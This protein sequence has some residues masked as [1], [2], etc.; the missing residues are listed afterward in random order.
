M[1]VT[2]TGATGLIGRHLVRRLRERGDE[3]TVLSRDPDRAR[4]SLGVEAVSWDPQAEPAPEAALAGRDA[5]VHLAGE[6]VAQRWSD[7]AKRAIRDSRTIGTRNLVSGL[8]AAEPRP[9]VLA[10]A[11]AVG[12]Y[13]PRGDEPVNESQPPGDDFLAQVCVDWEREADAAAAPGVRVVKLRTGIV[14]DR[15]GGALK[16]MLLPFKAG[17]GG[18]VAGG[19]QYMP[20]IHADD[21]VGMYLAALDGEAWSGAVNAT[22]PEPVTNAAFSKALGRTLKRPA[23]AP[24]PGFAAR[25]MLGE[26]SV[27]VTTGQR[28]VPKRAQELGYSFAHT[29]IDEALRSA[30]GRS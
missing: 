27:I 20:W 14:L 13:G 21:V 11:S 26:M 12:Y 18:P 4:D 30:V 16:Q 3:V 1:R 5:V 8:N 7:E 9:H 25:L 17:L 10:S 2:V 23:I 28:A 15:N 6:S 24:L 22:A 19:R 29:Q